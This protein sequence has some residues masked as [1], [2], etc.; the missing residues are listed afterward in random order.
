MLAVTNQV[1]QLRQNSGRGDEREAQCA[2]GLDT[3]FV[4]A[5]APIEK[6]NQRPRVDESA[7]SHDA[8]PGVL[9]PVFGPFRCVV[10]S[11]RR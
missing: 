5:V 9:A 6:R 11:L 4:P 7:S 10:N 3:R 1:K 8:G 2:E